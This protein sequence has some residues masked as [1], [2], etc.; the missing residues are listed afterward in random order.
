MLRRQE[1][2][3]TCYNNPYESIISTLPDMN[4]SDLKSFIDFVN[5]CISR[6]SMKCFR[7]IVIYQTSGSVSVDQ[8]DIEGPRRNS[9]FR[10][11]SP[12]ISQ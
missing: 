6:L 5:D 1:T 7:L 10:L 2:G 9:H 12:P 11:E 4:F 8:V 3:S